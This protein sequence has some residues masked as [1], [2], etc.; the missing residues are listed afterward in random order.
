MV[1]KQVPLLKFLL[2]LLWLI[3][4]SLHS[5]PLVIASSEGPPHT[6]NDIHHGI[7]LD[8]VEAVLNRLGYEV[9]YQFMG[10]KR[11]EREV[12][13]GRVDVMAPIF[14]KSD[15]PGSYISLPIVQYQPMVFSLKSSN[16]MPKTI[17]DMQGHSVVTFQG[18]PGYF[19]ADFVKLSK[20]SRYMELTDMATIP[21]LLVKGRYDY[22]VLDK[23]IFYYFYRLNDKTR[24]VSLFTEHSL[25]NSVPA[26]AAFHDVELRNQFNRELPRFMESEQYKQ[27]FERYL[28]ASLLSSEPVNHFKVEELP[29]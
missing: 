24:D 8:I 17:L 11:A 18:A 21:E 22:A 29:L 13:T 12:V 27:I 10:L 1:L 14:M 26:S 5:A 28:G 3:P 15:M 19:G 25:I 23:Y 9:E 2:P 6:I 16:V 4:V 7:D 20:E